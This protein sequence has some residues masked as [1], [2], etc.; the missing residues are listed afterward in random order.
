VPVVGPGILT[1]TRPGD[2]GDR[3]REAHAAFPGNDLPGVFLARGAARL[4]GSTRW[5]GT[6]GGSRDGHPEVTPRRRSCAQTVP[7]R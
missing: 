7:T 6:P 2:R 5:R 1:S 3:R 4:A